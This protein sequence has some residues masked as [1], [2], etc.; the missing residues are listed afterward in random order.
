MEE[1]YLNENEYDEG[2]PSITTYYKGE[3]PDVVD[4]YFTRYYHQKKS[5]NGDNE[6]H[7][8][9]LHSNR[10]CLVGLAKSHIAFTKGIVS[11]NYK[12]GNSDRSLNVVK[13]KHKKGGMNLQPDTALAVVKCQDG[14]EYKVVSCMMGKLIETNERIE[15]D[16]QILS[17]DGAGYIGV[18]MCKPEN[19]EKIKNSLTTQKDYKP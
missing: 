10:L 15:K 6:D 1:Y 14:S 4:R 3:Y 7:L 18:L 19:S 5:V 11:V 12:I 13:G 16:V 9:L 17:V 8:V 2:V